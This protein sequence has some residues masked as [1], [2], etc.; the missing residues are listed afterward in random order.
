MTARAAC[1]LVSLFAAPF[2]PVSGREPPDGI[3]G[4]LVCDYLWTGGLV[5]SG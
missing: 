2:H 3:I 4:R 1:D 5:A